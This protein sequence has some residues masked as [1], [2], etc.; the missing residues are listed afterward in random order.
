MKDSPPMIRRPLSDISKC[1]NA[2]FLVQLKRKKSQIKLLIKAV[3]LL[4]LIDRTVGKDSKVK[5]CL[6]SATRLTNLNQKE[7]NCQTYC[8]HEIFAKLF[9]S[10]CQAGLKK[11]HELLLIKLTF[12]EG[13]ITL[14]NHWHMKNWITFSSRAIAS[15]SNQ[16]LTQGVKYC[17][18]AKEDLFDWSLFD[19]YRSSLFRSKNL[20]FSALYT[21]AHCWWTSL[22]HIFLMASSLNLFGFNSSRVFS[23][24]NG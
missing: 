20:N 1:T 14:S 9:L 8:Y 23:H 19:Q 11:K 12:N 3:A 21:F 6:Q 7:F 10:H 16:A 15:K 22:K 5:W 18:N 17:S 24:N 13:H 2:L 4:W